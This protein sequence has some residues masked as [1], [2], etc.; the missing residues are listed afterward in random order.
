MLDSS[1]LKEFAD[2]NFKFDDNKRSYSNRQKTLREKEKLLVTSNFSFSHSVFKRLVLQT[3]KNQG[4]FG[5]GLNSVSSTLWL[6]GVTQGAFATSVDQVLTVQNKEPH[7]GST[8][9]KKI[10]LFSNQTFFF[11]VGRKV[12]LT[13]AA[14]KSLCFSLH[15]FVLNN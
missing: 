2:H 9:S 6:L 8:I 15:L 1:K 11:I 3:C 10:F 14:D 13:Q 5:K 12:F 4:L 7:V